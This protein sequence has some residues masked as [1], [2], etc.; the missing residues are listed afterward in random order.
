MAKDHP[1]NIQTK[2]ISLKPQY[3]NWEIFGKPMLMSS[4]K[5]QQI[6]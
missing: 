1:V 6:I 5:I 2:A 3:T 4:T